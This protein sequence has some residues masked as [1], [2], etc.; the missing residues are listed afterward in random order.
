MTTKNPAGSM[1]LIFDAMRNPLDPS[2]AEAARRRAGTGRQPTRSALLFFTVLALG[3]ML[4]VGGQALRQPADA[5]EK[6]H[7]QL[8]DQ[9]EAGQE[10]NDKSAASVQQL[11]REVANRQGAALQRKDQGSLKSRV[12]AATAAAGGTA[13]TAKGVKIT[14]DNPQPVKDGADSDPRTGTG[15][16]ALTSADMQQIVNALYQAGAQHIAINDQRLSS[17]SAVRFAGSAILVNYRPLTTPYTIEATGA[18][19]LKPRFDAGLGGRYISTLSKGGFTT[20]VSAET[21]TLPAV[22]SWRLDHAKV[23]K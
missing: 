22:E 14:L 11:R 10:R 8:V 4:G 6:R 7:Q 1:A 9:A 15:T 13:V 18:A 23:S 19:D 3:L 5:V 20:S 12:D 16:D 21:V 17:L 2:Y